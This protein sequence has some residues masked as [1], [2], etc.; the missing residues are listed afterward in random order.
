MTEVIKID[1]SLRCRANEIDQP[2]GNDFLMKERGVYAWIY[3]NRA[4]GRFT[5]VGKSVQNPF[6][7]RFSEHFKSFFGCGYALYEIDEDTDY[8]DFLAREVLG[9]KFDDSYLTAHD[10][11]CWYTRLDSHEFFRATFR[12]NIEKRLRILEH[13]LDHLEFVFGTV[14]GSN[15]QNFAQTVSRAEAGLGTVIHN[16]YLAE[17]QSRQVELSGSR[18]LQWPAGR[19]DDTLVG[20]HPLNKK[21]QPPIFE[22]R[23]APAEL[24]RI[25]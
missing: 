3:K 6:K 17:L 13:H 14:S 19:A 2:L 23:N 24:Q 11:I 22:H 18:G 1:W 10:K 25:L 8:L 15:G 21:V 9:R 12:T 4:N 20:R 5:Y 16:S 7:K